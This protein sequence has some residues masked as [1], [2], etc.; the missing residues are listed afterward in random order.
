MISEQTLENE[1]D[2]ASNCRR[3]RI[4]VLPFPERIVVVSI[5]HHIARTIYL[6]RS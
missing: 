2:E 1:E 4:A 3:I 5:F 6:I